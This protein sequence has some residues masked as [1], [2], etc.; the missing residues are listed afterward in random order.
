MKK[1]TLLLLLLSYFAAHAQEKITWP[2]HKKAVIILTYDDALHSQLNVAIPQLDSAGLKGT[3]FLTG[4]INA[5]TI[6]QWRKANKKGHEL[7]NHTVF[8]PCSSRD[9]NPM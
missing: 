2:D 7:A 4:D 5:Q 6:P 1:L 8:H 3:F 9:D